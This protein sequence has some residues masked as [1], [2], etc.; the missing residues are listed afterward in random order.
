[1]STGLINAVLFKY[2]AHFA[3]IF[4]SC[5]DLFGSSHVSG[6]LLISAKFIQKQHYTSW[7]SGLFICTAM[8]IIKEL[9]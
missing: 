8:V 2:Y 7:M 1:M 6:N 5:A 9:H 3:M 4:L